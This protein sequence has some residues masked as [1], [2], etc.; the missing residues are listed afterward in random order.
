MSLTRREAVARIAALA[1]LP[2]ARWHFSSAA[3][4]PLDGTIADYQAGR[5]RGDWTAAEVTTRA[6]ARCASE[7]K[8]WRAI[9]AL[10]PDRALA[11]A[12]A[13]DARLRAGKLRGPLDGVP[14]FAKSIYDMTKKNYTTPPQTWLDVSP[15]LWLGMGAFLLGIPIMFWWRSREQTFF[16]RRPDPVDSNPPPEGG[17]PLPPLLAPPDPD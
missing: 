1:A 3:P 10:L 16:R 9:D 13:S 2:L 4:D 7:G 6:L 11:E 15:V 12:R 17:H 5:R 8:K 14:V